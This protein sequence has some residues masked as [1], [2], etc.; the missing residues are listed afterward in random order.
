[1][2]LC[3][4]QN[5]AIFD[6]RWLQKRPHITQ[7]FGENPHIYKKYGLNSHSGIDFRT[8]EGTAV[9]A[10]IDGKVEVR[11]YKDRGLGLHVRISNSR[12]L[13]ILAHLSEVLVQTG[14]M[15]QMGN[16]IA[17]TGDTGYSTGPH[18]HIAAYKLKNN[19]I[20]DIANGWK[21]AFDIEPYMITFKGTTKQY[22]L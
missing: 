10:P 9:H 17:L 12:L 16:K 4:I 19:H 5:T 6:I 3:P 13:V 21:G 15:V 22:T 2:I 1:M 11:N 20:Q 14:S 7:R 18:L 8:V